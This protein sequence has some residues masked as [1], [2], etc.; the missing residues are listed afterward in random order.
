MHHSARITT[1]R[2]FLQAAAFA[3]GAFA[4]NRLAYPAAG[5][6][7]APAPTSAPS[8][9]F[10][11]PPGRYPPDAISE[12][13]RRLRPVGRAL[14]TEDYYVWCNSPIYDEAG[15]VHVYYSR[16]PARHGMSG[17]ISKCEI[18][19]AVADS[20]EAPFVF[21]AVV[22][23]PRPGRFDATTCH[24]P[25][26]HR[27]DGNYYLYYMGTS[28]GR[29]ASKRIGFAVSASPFGPW[30]RCDEPLLQPGPPGAWDDLC[31]T[32]PALIR[33]PG[34]KYWLYYKAINRDEYF[35]APKSERIKGNRRYGLA[36][37]DR[38]EGPFI[39]H[40]GNPV[41]DFS[42][43]EKNMQL[44]DAF[45]WLEDGRFKL[46]CRDM[47]F[48]DHFAGLLLE[49]S[50]GIR[51]SHPRIAYYGADAYALNEPPAPRHLSRYGRFERPQLLLKKGRPD[52]LFTSA[53][54][55]K[56]RTAS[57]F[58]FKIMPL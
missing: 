33:H 38:P 40:T 54:G 44:E 48:Y 52:Y 20:P 6:A 29:L 1:R 26:I 12:F 55:G 7:S 15:R 27:F 2:G 41:I 34:G 46:I 5:A 32:N 19:H 39:K 58:I 28:D 43:V 23:A 57:S 50:D 36:V 47:G 30:T 21:Q 51:F 9:S 17:W 37:A 56:Y 22:L 3:G 31:N 45:L 11:P 53:Q 24:N 25:T 13:S 16:W 14:E 42:R 49:S 10:A 18:A 4:F 8:P 35:N